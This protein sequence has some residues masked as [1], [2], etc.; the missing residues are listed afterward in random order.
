MELLL[1][2]AVVCHLIGDYLL[3]SDFLAKTKGSNYYHL[4]IHCILYTV[5]FMI[6]FG[7]DTYSLAILY[8]SH[9]VID[10]LKARFK[11]INYV[12]DQF[13]HYMIIFILYIN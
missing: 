10:V 11:L 3:Q 5:P 4:I 8:F 1:Y 2:K 7:Y 12:W 13:L 6:V 9:F